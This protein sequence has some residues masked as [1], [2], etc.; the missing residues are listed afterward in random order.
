MRF[1]RV[2]VEERI[3]AQHYGAV[4][5]VYQRGYHAVVQRRQINKY[6]NAAHQWQHGSD[7]AKTVKQRQGGEHPVGVLKVDDQLELPDVRHQVGVGQL[8]AFGHAFRTAGEKDDGRLLRPRVAGVARNADQVAE[9]R[10]EFLRAQHL[11][12]HVLEVNQLNP[13]L[14]ERIDVDSGPFEEKT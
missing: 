5:V 8:H 11:P 10:E 13:V 3:R 1:A 7:K 12:A 4:P 9:L 14:D 2:A 6:V